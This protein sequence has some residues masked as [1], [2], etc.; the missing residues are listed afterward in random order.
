MRLLRQF[1]VVR[2]P[3]NQKQFSRVY[4]GKALRV[5]LALLLLW[6]HALL[7]ATLFTTTGDAATW[8]AHTTASV[9]AQN[10][11]SRRETHAAWEAALEVQ[12]DSL[13]NELSVADRVGQLFLVVFPGHDTGFES[14]IAEL[15][16]GY[17]VGGVVLTPRT[18]NFTNQSNTDTPYAVAALV[19]R[20]QA[21]AYGVL[22]PE[23]A[24]IPANANFADAETEN[25]LD[26]LSEELIQGPSSAPSAPEIAQEESQDGAQEQEQP[27]AEEEGATDG[28]SGDAAG[29]EQ[30][31]ATPPPPLPLL[32]E[33]TGVPPVNLP[34]FVAIEQ[35]GD[36]LP[37]TAL[38]RG[39]TPLP[40]QMALGA[41][42]NTELTYRT[43]ALVG[44]EL[45]AVGVNMLLGPSLNVIE[46]PRLNEVGSLGLQSFGGNPYWVAQHARAYISGVYAG[47]DGRIATIAGDF[48]G[49]GDIDR[50]PEQEI[51]TVQRS[52]SQLRHNALPPFWA[53]TRRPSAI[54][55]PGGESA[56]AAGLMSSPTRYSAFQGSGSGR[57]TPLN[58]TPELE[59]VLEQEGL[60]AWQERGGVIVSP[61]LGSPSIRRYYSPA[62]EEF[63]HR[64]IALDAFTAGHDLLLLDQYSLDDNWETQMRNIQA[65][66]GFFQERYVNDPAFAQQVDE[67]VRRILRL[68]LGLYGFEPPEMPISP[69]HPI[70]FS[71][72][73]LEDILI[74]QTHLEHLDDDHRMTAQAIVG[75]VARESLSTLY[76]DAGS[77]SE[78]LS[79]VPQGDDNIVI[80]T[81]SRLLQECSGCLAEPAVGP[82]VLGEI[83]LDFYGPGAT[84]QLN[85]EQIV[86]LTF[87]DLAE[88][89]ENEFV[90]G[91]SEPPPTDTPLG[92]SGQIDEEATERQLDKA[93]KINLQLAEAD[94][95]LFAMLDVNEEA[96][97]HSSAIKRFL[98]ERGDALSGKNIVVFALHAPYYL[99]A[100]ELSKLHAYYGVYGKTQPFIENAVRGFFRSYTPSG[101]PPV[102]VAGTRF[103]DLLE[104]TQPAPDRAIDLQIL[105]ADGE[106][107]VALDP[108]DS[109]DVP[110]IDAGESI[111]T[112]AGPLIDRNGKI[113]HDGLPV[114]FL[115]FYDNADSP[116]YQESATTRAGMASREV[117]IEQPGNL[118]IEAYAGEGARALPLAM[119]VIGDRT[120]DVAQATD[121]GSPTE[122]GTAEVDDDS[123]AHATAD[124]TSNGSEPADDARTTVDAGTT[125]GA[126]AATGES[127]EAADPALETL[128]TVTDTAAISLGQDGGSM[129]LLAPG[130]RVTLAS[131]V[132]T[133]FA[134]A[135]VLGLLLVVQIRI[136]PRRTVVQSTLWAIVFGLAAYVLYGVGLAP[137]GYLL[138]SNLR[139][140]GPVVLVVVAMLPPILW[141]GLRSE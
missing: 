134:M 107:I 5:F 17:R 130:Q 11:G 133:L 14:D 137:F 78:L 89:L 116:T 49:A 68:K 121:N 25:L 55:T 105:D 76:P 27:E 129:G 23:N 98:R 72:I 115:I 44:K 74:T 19:N 18:G 64:R 8:G 15:I 92:D 141:V 50:L 87:A 88:V 83:M 43:G 139:I 12:V 52:L 60:S 91:E 108:E 125:D 135:G 38:R 140:W 31:G 13:M 26:E 3:R 120:E 118:R 21:L 84:G 99:D 96:Y 29:D 136:L 57:A 35:R 117:T 103:A 40:S 32:E 85:P 46:P 9:Y 62:Q 28:E 122:N 70:M 126:T 86:S 36:H 47:S 42:W 58:L 6:T 128:E 112:Q 61:P 77:A 22:L 119:Q 71:K 16:H 48:P 123:A 124:E 24:S 53:V 2:H 114:E 73:G 1:P 113:V 10:N 51:A 30:T 138:E 82:D 93:A 69:L 4:L 95:I 20:L 7:P 34:L 63:P 65:T 102:S 94:W 127:T 109:T 110:A 101:A 100:T 59:S 56:G 97:P 45:N 111:R 79:T 66:I 75:Q 33:L 132:I 37:A 106:T 80:F 54:L 41:A 81:E 39:F 67:S 90:V 131:F 104:R